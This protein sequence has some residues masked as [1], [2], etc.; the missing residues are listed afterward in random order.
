MKR[1]IQIL[2]CLLP[3]LTIGQ[4][5]KSK[6]V[7]FI[8][9]SANLKI[10]DPRTEQLVNPLGLDI[11]QPRFSWKLESIQQNTIQTAFEIT[12]AT[13]DDFNKKSIWWTNKK[14][15]D[16]SIYNKYE[17]PA[18]ASNTRY[19]WYVKVWDNHGNVSTAAPQYWHTGFFNNSEWTGKWI[20]RN[21][22]ASANQ[23][24]Y[25]SPLLRKEF[26][27]SKAVKSAMLFITGKGLYEAHINGK[28]VG[29]DFLTPGWTS[30]NKRTQ[31]QVYDV[32][33]MLK[34][35]DN[36]IG[37]MLGKG[38]FKGELGWV[39][40][41]NLYGNSLA[42]LAQVMITFTD[43]TKQVVQSDDTW[44]SALGPILDSEIYHGEK[45]DARLEKPGWDDIGF[46]D[47]TWDKVVALN[48]GTNHL[49]GTYGP[50][51][52]KREIIKP[53]KLITTP[54][55]DT[56]LD[57][58]QN[59]VGWVK[60]KATGPAGTTI[61]LWHA[62]VLDKKGNFY[63]E[64]LRNAKQLN[65]YTL[66]GKGEEIFEPHFTFQGFRY[67]KISGYPGPVLLDHFEGVVVYSDMEKTG[68]F[69]C[70]NPLVN[71]LQH[72]IQ[73]GQ[74]GNFVDVPT[75]C[76]QRDERLGWTG[77]AQAFSR[78]AAFNFNVQN[79]FAKWLL[80]L[81]ADQN[82]NGSIPHVVP[83]ALNP[84][85]SASAGWADA[86]TIIPWN[87]YW[88]YGDKSFLERQYPSMKLWL[89]YMQDSSK[90]YLWN[91][92]FHFGDWLFYSIGDDRDGKS[93]VT[94]KYLIAQCFFA[95][96]VQLMINTAAVLNK[97]DDVQFY[98]DLLAKVKTAFQNEYVTANGRMISGTQTAYVLAL[99]FD[100]LPPSLRP[101]AVN[102]LVN[103]I[104]SYHY[105]I[106]TGFLGTPYICHVLSKYGQ[107]DV[108]Y[109]LLFQD[110]YPSW[111]YPVK[112]GATTIWERW[113][114]IKPDGDFQ[115][116]SMNSFNHY[117]YGAIGDWMYRSVAGIEIEMEGYKKSIIRP[118]LTDA[119][120]F[121]SAG[122]ATPYG[123][124]RSGW[125]RNE[126]GVE[127]SIEIPANTSSTVILPTAELTRLTIDGISIS[128][129]EYGQKAIIVDKEVKIALGSGKYTIRL[130]N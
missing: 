67:I 57:F 8:V 48:A 90:N 96:S 24:V 19:Y 39:N 93:A 113:D 53:I 69:E 121:A 29:N 16:Q 31:Y 30:Y 18:L 111:L 49:V 82:P 25:P 44:S 75:D 47:N 112:M 32:T 103:N 28:K 130:A 106:T 94:D 97:M 78:T 108:A 86:G 51:V 92:G 120:N 7:S 117:A 42:L 115:T 26:T 3:L 110:T 55:K 61:K 41:N 95:N 59:M 11:Q 66:A 101:Y 119:L 10:V 46:T 84:G 4:K 6:I 15:S 38:W 124:I 58:G 2:F 71:Q 27:L 109:K 1:F 43:G 5:N 77:D 65:E 45:I 12:V 127:F 107:A 72:N 87:M 123:S 129:S 125:Y 114:G 91:K 89:K 76:P 50:A 85:A 116:A 74:R 35:G 104:K 126:G 88:I 100:M 52:R 118:T 54:E 14:E 20:G 23:K 102:Q 56:V 81:A 122:T 9:T 34:K 105:H 128:S 21:D 33:G 60:V 40:H 64:N 37:A 36:A 70:S 62:E 68:T 73:W 80:D 98:T 79:F 17:G 63:I 22:E 13:A 83:N 99:Q